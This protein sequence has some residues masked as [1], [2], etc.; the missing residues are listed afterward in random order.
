MTMRAI[1]VLIL[2]CSALVQ[3]CEHIH[4]YIYICDPVCLSVCMFTH[5]S[6][7]FER[8]MLTLCRRA[9]VHMRIVCTLTQF[10]NSPVVGILRINLK[11]TQSNNSSSVRIIVSNAMRIFYDCSELR[12][13]SFVQYELFVEP[14][15][16][17]DIWA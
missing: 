16:V 7:S 13:R 11:W 10:K 5:I 12:D 8:K 9:R 3:V 15:V 14:A 1:V 17:N 4:I 2:V 6:V